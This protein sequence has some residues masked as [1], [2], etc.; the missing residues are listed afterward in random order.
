QQNKSDVLKTLKNKLT[1]GNS[2]EEAFKK[3]VCFKCQGLGH[4]SKVCPNR[5][6][7]TRQE[8]YN[9]LMQNMDELVEQE[10]ELVQQALMQDNKLTIGNSKEEAFKKPVCFKCQGLGH[11]SK[12]CPNRT[13]VTR[14]EYYNF[15]MQNMDELVE[16][17]QELVQQ[18]LMQDN[19]LTIGNSK[20]EAFKKP[21]CFKCQGLGHVSKVC[22]NRTMVTRQEYYNF[23][24]QNMDELVE[25]EQELVQQALM[26]DNKLT[27]GNS[28]EEA[29]KK[30]VCFKCQGLGHVSKVCPNR[31]MVTRQEYYNFLMQNMDELV[32]QEQELVQQALMQ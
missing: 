11:V 16:Q 22:P 5:T 19:K 6:M 14:Q 17:E 29:F 24:M 31:T 28:K 1:I 30:P 9:F 15:L 2:K 20:E 27:I 7:V 13:M 23:L 12:V 25:Q 10:Q 18:A 3:P 21:V 8:Y 26:Q 32:E 4:V